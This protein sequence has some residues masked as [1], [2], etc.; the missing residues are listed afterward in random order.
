MGR[1]RRGGEEVVYYLKELIVV[2]FGFQVAAVFDGFFESGGFGRESHFCGCL[3][4]LSFLGWEAVL[5][6]LKVVL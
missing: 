3:G 1:R 2:G 6:L 4:W 5:G